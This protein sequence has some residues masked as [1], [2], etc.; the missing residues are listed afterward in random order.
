MFWAPRSVTLT[1]DGC[2][3]WKGATMVERLWKPGTLLVVAVVC[4]ASAVGNGLYDEDFSNLATIVFSV[5]GSLFL[6][7]AIVRAS[8]AHEGSHPG[9]S[10]TRPATGPSGPAD[11]RKSCARPIGPTSRGTWAADRDPAPD[12]AWPRSRLGR[13]AC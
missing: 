6:A 2:Q 8:V 3:R 5:L 1:G 7:A 4:L 9:P 13:P 11:S 12:S 10:T